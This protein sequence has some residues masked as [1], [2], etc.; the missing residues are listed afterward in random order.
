MHERGLLASTDAGRQTLTVRRMTEGCRREV[1]HLKVGTLS[2]ADAPDQP[3]HARGGALGGRAAGQASPVAPT[4]FLTTTHAR[5]CAP[6][7]NSPADGQVGRAGDKVDPAPSPTSA[8]GWSG[9]NPDLTSAPTSKP[10][11][12]V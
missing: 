11:N 3:D 4:T 9:A 1:L 8:P 12:G 2:T 6:A 5:N 7:H 10:T